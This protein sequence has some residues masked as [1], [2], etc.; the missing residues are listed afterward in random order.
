[1]INIKHLLKL[2]K[3][4][5]VHK[6]LKIA[7]EISEKESIPAYVVGG[8]VRDLI[9]GKKINDIDIMT[10][11]DGIE[12]A[13]KI[14]KQIEV[15]KVIPFEK[16]GTALIPNKDIQ[17]EV[18]TARKESYESTSRKPTEVIY[19]DLKGDLVRRDFTINAMSMDIH[20]KK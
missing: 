9:M 15:K 6:V 14:A 5:S 16:F 18:A 19:T 13:K 1:M 12:F 17:I 2:V 10:I 11:G 3:N 20:P 4:K 7:G 8:F